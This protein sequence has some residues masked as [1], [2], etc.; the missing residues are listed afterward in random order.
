MNR[1]S[2]NK[3]ETFEIDDFSVRR[4]G[5]AEAKPLIRGCGHHKHRSTSVPEAGDHELPELV[6]HHWRNGSHENARGDLQEPLRQCA[7]MAG[8]HPLVRQDDHDAT[9]GGGSQRC[10][11]SSPGSIGDPMTASMSA[12]MRS[13]NRAERKA[14]RHAV[15]TRPSTSWV[16]SATTWNAVGTATSSL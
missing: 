7:A 9:S 3:K 2:T 10:G 6:T 15:R 14:P 1:P 5:D 4:P 13:K 8:C 11:W 12:T 16:D